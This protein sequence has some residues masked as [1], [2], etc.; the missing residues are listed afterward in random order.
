MC[1][2]PLLLVYVLLLIGRALTGV[3]SSF[4]PHQHFASAL[5]QAAKG[6]FDTA[7]EGVG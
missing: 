5:A 1:A 6:E 4:A 2:P 3:D 7:S